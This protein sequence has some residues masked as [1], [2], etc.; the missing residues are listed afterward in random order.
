VPPPIVRRTPLH[1]T[2]PRHSKQ[3]AATPQQPDNGPGWEWDKESISDEDSPYPWSRLFPKREKKKPYFIREWLSEADPGLNQ[4]LISSGT[5]ISQLF[6]QDKWENHRSMKRYFRE[7]KLMPQSTVL[8]RIAKPC[9]SV[10]AVGLFVLVWNDFVVPLLCANLVSMPPERLTLG[11]GFISHSLIGGAISLLLVFRTNSCHARFNEGRLLWGRAVAAARRWCM[12][13]SMGV[14]TEHRARSRDYIKVWAVLLKS[15][16]R[17][18]RTRVT[19]SDPT[20]YRDDPTPYVRSVLTRQEA[21]FVM[22]Q[23]NKPLVMLAYMTAVMNHVVPH[24]TYTTHAKIQETLDELGNIAGGCE[25]LLSTPIPLSYTRHSVRALL[26]WLL[27]APLAL[28]HHCGWAMLPMLYFMSFLMLGI[29]EL[30][31]QIEEPFSILPLTPLVE[32]IKREADEL[33]DM[34]DG[35][36]EA[37]RPEGG[38]A[39]SSPATPATIRA[40][41]RG[42]NGST[43]EGDSCAE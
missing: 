39:A 26:I 22:Q 28:Y 3:G 20:A 16:L 35:L 34:A 14:P 13:M 1:A 7:L 9:T 19:T 6:D 42:G 5:T 25:R 32:V 23:K 36:M 40:H 43:P 18:G 37:T 30:A 15:H 38:P 4:S 29:D 17:A 33:F 27:T 2:E 10:A 24:V 31:A 8:R 12:L 41:G 11:M 21:D